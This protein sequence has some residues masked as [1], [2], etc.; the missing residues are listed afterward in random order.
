MGGSPLVLEIGDGEF[1]I[2][3]TRSRGKKRVAGPVYVVQEG[4]LTFMYFG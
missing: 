1:L 2:Y 3:A 4:N